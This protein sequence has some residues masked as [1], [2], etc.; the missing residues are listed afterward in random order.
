M[1]RYVLKAPDDSLLQALAEFRY[2]L[3][4]FILFSEQAAE[5]MGLHPQ[6]H[7]LLLQVAGCEPGIAATVAYAADRLGLRHNSAV[8]LVDRCV[9][10]DLLVRSSDPRDAR[11]VLLQISTKGRRMLLSLSDSHARELDELAPL[12]IKSL[13]RVRKW[14]KRHR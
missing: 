3:R 2:R 13:R 11:R 8:E 14:R 5:A 1:L 12:L 9:K 7:Q 4:T 10:Q 6:Q